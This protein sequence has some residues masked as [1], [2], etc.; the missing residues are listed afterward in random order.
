MQFLIFFGSMI[1]FIAF[2]Y[3]LIYVDSNDSGPFSGL[4][5]LLWYTIPN[6]TRSLILTIFGET[7]AD[8]IDSLAVYIC[9]KPNPLVQI[10]YVAFMSI[11]FTIY[12]KNGFSQLPGP[13]ASDRHI[14]TG[15]FLFLICVYVYYKACTTRPGY[16]T[17]KTVK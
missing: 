10:A 5:R 2:V 6:A 8:K 7:I 11:G 17:K 1:G 9:K 16:V 12:Y 3:L 4:K 14:K 13:Y 15:S